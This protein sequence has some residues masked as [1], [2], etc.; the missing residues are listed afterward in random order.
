MGSLIPVDTLSGVASR[1]RRIGPVAEGF[2]KG[3]IQGD[4]AY[5][6]VLEVQSRRPS[7]TVI[8]VGCGEGYLLALLVERFYRFE[9]L[10]IDHDERRLSQARLALGDVQTIRLESLD[11]RAA[12]L[13]PADLV[14][15]LDVLHYLPAEDQDTVLR[16]LSDA[17]RPGGTLLI[18]DGVAGLGWRSAVSRWSERLMVAIGR[19]QGDGVFFRPADDTRR[20][21]V[22]AGLEVEVR[23]CWAGTPF[24]NVMFEAR[25]PEGP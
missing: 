1:Y 24:A 3:K 25:R 6:A 15:V 18:R 4:P 7:G 9:G 21:L 12:D 5:Q 19:H 11:V 17:L 20:A 2:A 10:G 8:D 22:A 14:V 13:P 23:P 16:A